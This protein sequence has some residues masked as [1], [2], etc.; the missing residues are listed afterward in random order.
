M[1]ATPNV[2]V[3][4]KLQHDGGNRRGDCT[5]KYNEAM[6]G[7]SRITHGWQ[8]W[9]FDKTS[10]V[11]TPKNQRDS[12]RVEPAGG[13]SSSRFAEPGSAAP[14]MISRSAAT[15][16]RSFSRAEAD[17]SSISDSGAR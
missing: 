5:N 7:F 3:A 13:V 4:N 15:S 14:A 10:A 1:R 11:Q 6:F 9:V 2:A 12:S 16:S 17:F 8:R